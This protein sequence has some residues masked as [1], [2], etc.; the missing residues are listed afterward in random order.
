[1]SYKGGHFVEKKND[2]MIKMVRYAQ[3][4]HIYL[5]L[6]SI[7][8]QSNFCSW[9]SWLEFMQNHCKCIYVLVSKSLSW[10][11]LL[12]KNLF[13]LFLCATLSKI[14]LVTYL[15]NESELGCL[16]HILLE[17]I[18]QSV[19]PISPYDNVAYDNAVYFYTTKW[20]ST[21]WSSTLWFQAMKNP[22]YATA[23]K[24]VW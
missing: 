17:K 8:W 20:S 21:M 6:Y 11:L 3:I 23:R 7:Q 14:S 1:M 4:A 12:S 22:N 10:G 9:K 24:T 19:L 2:E 18:R 13:V 15:S 5:A 16:L